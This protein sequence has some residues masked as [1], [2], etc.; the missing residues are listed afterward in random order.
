MIFY[1]FSIFTFSTDE[2]VFFFCKIVFKVSD[3]IEIVL[4]GF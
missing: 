1:N 2:K 3:D 4:N